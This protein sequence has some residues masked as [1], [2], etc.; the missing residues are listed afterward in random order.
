[1]AND[2][3]RQLPDFVVLHHKYL[4]E[5]RIMAF[6]PHVLVFV[7][8]SRHNVGDI[9]PKFCINMINAAYFHTPNKLLN[10]KTLALKFPLVNLLVKLMDLGP[11]CHI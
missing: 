10:F 1:M 11:I 8:P 7:W 3:W 5:N 6:T 9:E 4:Y 2:K